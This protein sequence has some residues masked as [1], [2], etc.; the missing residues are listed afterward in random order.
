MVRGGDMEEVDSE[1][2]IS[3]IL[4]SCLRAKWNFD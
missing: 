3:V 4:P 2:A 1:S